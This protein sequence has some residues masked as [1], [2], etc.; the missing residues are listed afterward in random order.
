MMKPYP[1]SVLNYEKGFS[2]IIN[3]LKTPVENSICYYFDYDARSYSV[4]MSF[5]H[6]HMFY[7]IMILLSPKAYHFIAGKPYSIIN[8][9]IV[10]LAPAI[11]H[12]TEYLP[13]PPSDRII[14]NFMVPKHL[15]LHP[16]GYDRILS[17]FNDPVP[18]FR[19]DL[20]RQK[21]LFQLINQLTE[22]SHTVEDPAIR[23]MM[24]NNKFTEFLFTL[25]QMRNENLYEYNSERSIKEKIYTITN[26]IQTHYNEDLSLA[27]LADKF[28]ISSFYLSHQFK[29][30][31][32]FT[33]VQYIQQTRVK[34]AQYLLLNTS[35]KITDIAEK[36]GFSS[37]SQFN[38]VFHRFCSM[39]PSDY[40]TFYNE[41]AMRVNVPMMSTKSNL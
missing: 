15:L 2:I 11:L 7:E 31:T 9:D 37:F 16:E 13:G 17:I 38:R 23:N 25:Y 39:S 21:T 8:N 30:V 24:I 5:P 34:N 40:K 26:Y 33:V 10:L 29:L 32:G 1:D 20:E 35:L 36:I 19:F 12:Q 3:E 41:N 14:I 28:F 6:M 27:Y 22:L 4:N 18:I